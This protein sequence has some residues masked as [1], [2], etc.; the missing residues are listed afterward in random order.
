MGGSGYKD[1]IKLP[2]KIDPWGVSKVEFRIDQDDE[3]QMKKILIRDIEDNEIIVA[4]NEPVVIGGTGR[5]WV[6]VKSMIR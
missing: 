1:Q 3:K 5:T 6:K 2:I 4:E